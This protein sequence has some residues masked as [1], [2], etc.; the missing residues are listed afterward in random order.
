MY[1]QA[2]EISNFKSFK[3]EIT[4]PLDRGFT[5][6][7]GPNGSGKSNCGDAIQFVLGPRSNKVIRAQ[8]AKDLIFNGGKN[9]KPARSCEVTLVF[10]NP[11]LSSGRRRL[12]LDQDQVRMTRSVRL[13][14]SNNTITTYSLDGEESSQKTFHRLLGAANAR[15]DGY[16]IVLQGD[17]TKLAK[18]TAKE[19]RKVLDSV[20][21][22]TS[23]DDE[24]RKADRQKEMVEGY[25]ERI[26]LLEDEQ[27]ARLKDLTK[28]KN[29]ALKVQDLVADL[30]LARI[31]SAQSKLASQNSERK[32]M[33]D[34]RV[35]I[36]E[37]ASH[38]EEAVKE[39]AKTFLILEDKIGVLQKQIEDLMGGDS[40]GLLGAIS[41]LQI[42]IATSED[43]ISEAEDKDLEDKEE[44]VELVESLQQAQTSLDE[45]KQELVNA[46]SDLKNAEL[47]LLEAKKEEAEVQLLL[48]SSGTA[49]AELSRSLSKAILVTEKATEDLG[50]AQNEVNRVAT[51]AEMLSEQLSTAQESAESARLALGESQLEGEQLGADAPDQDRRK[52]GEQLLTNQRSEAKLLEESQ[53]IETR[54]RET[55]RKLNTAKNELENKSGAKGMAGGAAAII[56]ARDRGE[57]SGIIGTVAELCQPRDPAHTDALA[58]AVGGGMTSVVVDSDEVAAK[59]IQW[60]AQ[61]K[62]GRATFLPLNKLTQSRAAG[63]AL[64]VSKKPGVIG[65]ANELLDFDP[66]IDIA[67]RFVLRNTLIVDNMSTARMNMGGVRLVTLRGDVTEAGGAMV[68]GSRRKSHVSFGGNIQ[69]AS[70]VEALSSDVDR[71]RLMSDT[72]NGA[73]SDARRLQSETRAKINA[74]SDGDHAVRFQ[75]WRAEHKQAQTNHTTALGEVAKHEKRLVELKLEGTNKIRELDQAQQHLGEVNQQRA[76]A[77]SALEDASPEHLK[78]RLHAAEVKRVEAEGLKVQAEI[79]L[80]GDSSHQTLLSSRVDEIS[81]RITQLNENAITRSDRMD[82]LQAGV[83]TDSIELKAKEDERFQFLEENQGLEEERLELIEERTSL[84]MNLQQKSTD[85]R[86]RRSLVEEMGRTLALKDESIRETKQEMIE[87][88]IEFADE[89][90]ILPSVG[91]AERNE[92]TLQRKLDSHGPVT[93]LAIEQFDACEARLSEM[94]GDFKTLQDRRKHL[95]DVTEKLESQRKERLLKVLV[96]VNENFKVAYKSLSDGGRGE[97][98]LENKDEPFKGGLELWAQPRG[99][100]A[101]VTRHQLSGGEQSMAALALIFAIQDYDPS[102]FYYFDEVDQ[103][104]DG[105]N[106]ER[107][108]L[109]CRERS[110]RAQFIMVTLRK[111]SLRLADHHI[112]VTHGGDGCSRRIVDFDREKAIALGERALAE[113][114]KDNAKNHSR[115]EEA[116]A[117]SHEMPEVPEA[118]PTP[119][120]LGGLL[121]HM[122]APEETVEETVEPSLGLAALSERTADMTEDIEEY[123]EVAQAIQAVEAEE[124]SQVAEEVAEAE[125]DTV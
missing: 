70:E 52:L 29:L 15:P 80:N 49:N 76:E 120:S 35:R 106:A 98:F 13:S 68:G 17:V 91:D 73:L 63:K 7:T 21:G 41:Q 16:N 78:D 44:L 115:I 123:T 37:E 114:E 33:V 23:Y 27:K 38:L 26:G 69:G 6:I 103:N 4:I 22:V 2:L 79:S 24:I 121:N 42:R 101:K 5:A 97:L 90:A 87:N 104:L 20:A 75:E 99:K 46:S 36:D 105:Y 53:A 124:Q 25:I 82:T 100:S 64:M 93:M 45:F 113:A 34:E 109:M 59:A 40:N 107:I 94:K 10:A 86:S 18:M 77:Q 118:L 110:K 12:P 8:N 111:V 30:K 102:P 14:K 50:L 88:N 117:A 66:R 3:G 84:Q 67:V 19:R 125:E 92:R 89:D 57:L 11:L 122:P 65:F 54:L 112:G 39:G 96:K 83:A 51:Q 1:L 43:R 119:G 9:S 108:A 116:S 31:I 74:L 58:T 56:A 61:N 85:A 28:E 47:A 71:F 55:E 95:I 48:E 60:L 72:V 62:A 32:Y 81:Q